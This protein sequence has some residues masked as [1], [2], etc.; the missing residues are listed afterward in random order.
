MSVARYDNVEPPEVVSLVPNEL[1]RSW[2]ISYSSVGSLAVAWDVTAI[3]CCGLG[4]GLAYNYLAFGSVGQRLLYLSTSFVLA[5]GFVCILKLRDLYNPSELLNLRIQLRDIT[6]TWISVFLFLFG[7][8]FTLKIAGNYSRVAIFS[9]GISGLL[10]LAVQRFIYRA[11]LVRGLRDEKFAGRKAILITEKLAENDNWL[12]SNLLKYG[13]KL[14]RHFILPSNE[15]S[16]THEQFVSEVVNYVRG[17]DIEE[18]ILNLDLM[19]W[20]D[21]DKTVSGLRALPL[22]INLIPAGILSDI[23]SRPSRVIGQSVCV[24]LQRGALNSFERGIKRA[25]DILMSLFGIALFLPLMT[26]VALAI[27]LDSSGPIFFRQQRCGFN[28]RRFHILKFRTMAVLE[29][30]PQIVQATPADQRVTQVGR[31]LRKS[32]I[33]ELPQ[34]FNVLSG[35]MSLVG[36]RPHAVA[37]DSLFD[38]VVGNYAF[39]HHVKPGLTG[40]AQVNGHRGPTPTLNDIRKR[41]QFDLYYIDNWS[42]RFDFTIMLRT[43]IELLRARNAY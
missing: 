6:T 18:V 23:V 16:V 7:V 11:I 25:V 31:W 34:L 22:P 28:G 24:E 13:F 3:L 17:S 43:V 20:P 36:P 32:S 27:T 41:V 12:S 1:R 8:V 37:H 21:F 19:R 5:V 30:G 26:V 10:L 2:P 40:W 4:C 35:T 9:F 42:L 29:D 15:S 38:K 14:R 33:D 39:R